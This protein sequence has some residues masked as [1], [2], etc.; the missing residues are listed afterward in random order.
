MGARLFWG[1]LL[2]NGAAFAMMG[3]DKGKARNRRW[4]IPEKRLWMV[5]FLGGAGGA[6]LGMVIFRH[7]IRNGMFRAGLPLLFFVQ[8]AFLL[9][10]LSG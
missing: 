3:A 2:T 9:S 1:W 6:W 4:R 10:F 7:K 8:L 5:A